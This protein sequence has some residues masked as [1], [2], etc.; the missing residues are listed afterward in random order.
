MRLNS[1]LVKSSIID[2]FKYIN[3]DNSIRLKTLDSLENHLKFKNQ[4]LHLLE[5][6]EK[7]IKGNDNTRLVLDI[8]ENL[9]TKWRF[10]AFDSSSKFR[11]KYYDENLFDSYFFYEKG[12]DSD[13]KNNIQ[14]NTILYSKSDKKQFINDLVLFRPVKG[15]RKYK[16]FQ[17]LKKI[18]LHKHLGARNGCVLDIELPNDEKQH[19][20]SSKQSFLLKTLYYSEDG[21]DI[22]IKMQNLSNQDVLILK[23]KVSDETN[24]YDEVLTYFENFDNKSTNLTEII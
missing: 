1:D 24:S 9:K 19:F 13:Y 8:I 5:V 22:F 7:G 2:D 23:G 10:Y 3:L 6:V 17:K 12:K 15:K 20:R 18:F 14:T 16:E 4:K 21:R 11:Y